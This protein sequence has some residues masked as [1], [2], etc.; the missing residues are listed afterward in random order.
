[1]GS[2]THTFVSAI[3]DGADPTL[4]RPSNW[5]AG[6]T[7]ALS[8]ADVSGLG[9]IATQ[10]ANNVAITGGAI[11]G[12]SLDITGASVISVA[13][14]ADIIAAEQGSTPGTITLSRLGG[15]LHPAFATGRLTL[16]SGNAIPTTDQSAKGTLYY[17]DTS[18]DG[19][20][21]G[22]SFM[23][24]IFDGTRLRLY[25]SVEISLAVTLTINKVYDVFIF[26]NAGT[27]ALELSAAWSG[28]GTRTDALA[29]QS[30]QIVKSGTTTRRWLGS[31]W[32]SGT[33]QISDTAALVGVGNAYNAVPRKLEFFSSAT[34]W[35]YNS[36]TIRQAAGATANKVSGVCAWASTPVSLEVGVTTIP[37]VGTRSLIG[38]G[39]DVTNAYS[40][41]SSRL[42]GQ[43]NAN[44]GHVFGKYVDTPGI[45]YHDFNWLES[46]DAAST[47]TF[48]TSAFAAA[49]QSGISGWIMA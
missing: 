21:T 41:H 46:I 20:L 27:L 38:I 19:T 13:T 39:V 16:V 36:T 14:L 5:N 37:T 25:S 42:S 28:I 40:A 6:H 34:A 2:I 4:V 26:D 11:S 8:T 33:N 32:A 48:Y 1:M 49:I 7:F 12:T 35:T 9:T 47:S 24:S 45:G 29:S 23:V 44:N 18:N 30:G 3:P 15:L 17:T 43:S 10:N 31:I 22:N